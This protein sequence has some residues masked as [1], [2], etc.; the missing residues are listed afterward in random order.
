MM[1][2]PNTL[3]QRNPELKGI[4]DQ[5]SG[6]VLLR[7]IAEKTCRR[8]NSGSDAQLRQTPLASGQKAPQNTE[9]TRNDGY[10]TSL[11]IEPMAVVVALRESLAG[12]DSRCISLHTVKRAK[13]LF[14][15]HCDDFFASESI[16]LSVQ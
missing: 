8:L 6:M 9:R 1:V 14:R 11:N 2:C 10:F 12:I 15:P 4:P 5:L 16:Q 13:T 3:V 7:L